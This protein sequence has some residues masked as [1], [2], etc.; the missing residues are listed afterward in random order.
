MQRL[1][2]GR[3]ERY[4]SDGGVMLFLSLNVTSV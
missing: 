2:G 3:C 4:T 1:G